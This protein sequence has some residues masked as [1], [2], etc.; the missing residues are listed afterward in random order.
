[1][2]QLKPTEGA[3]LFQSFGE[4][5]TSGCVE[6]LPTNCTVVSWPV[7]AIPQSASCIDMPAG[8]TGAA[9]RPES[10]YG[11]PYHSQCTPRFSVRS[12]RNFQSSLKN[13]LNS[14]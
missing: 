4:D 12:E 13:V 11:A 10:S 3:K 6:F 14:L 2:F 5:R 8:T 1:M 9:A 7:Q